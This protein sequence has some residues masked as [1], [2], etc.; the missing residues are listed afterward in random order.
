MAACGTGTLGV[1]ATS[2]GGAAESSSVAGSGG[3]GGLTTD[4]H[5]AALAIEYQAERHSNDVDFSRSS[6]LRWHNPLKR[7][8]SARR[9]G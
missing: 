2:G 9:R 6:G 3:A 5:L 8:S 7:A 1:E 4:T